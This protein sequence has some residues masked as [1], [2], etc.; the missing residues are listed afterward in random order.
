MLGIPPKYLFF[1]LYFFYSFL[2][3]ILHSIILFV[4]SL[5][6][7]NICSMCV[8]IHLN[9]VCSYSFKYMDLQIFLFQPNV[10][11]LNICERNHEN[12]NEEHD[13]S[14][15]EMRW[16]KNMVKLHIFLFSW[17]YVVSKKLFILFIFCCWK[18]F[19]FYGYV[20]TFQ[21][22][23]AFKIEFSVRKWN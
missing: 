12:I 22:I 20:F 1:F 18:A 8:H 11:C 10:H 7:L 23:C 4:F 13:H 15:C 9:I 2:L 17:Y 6:T 5:N 16:M 3:S 21:D 14:I 19:F